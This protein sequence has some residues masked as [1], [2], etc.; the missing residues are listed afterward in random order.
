GGAYSVTVAGA[1]RVEQIGKYAPNLEYRTAPI[2]PPKGGIAKAGDSG[3]NFMIMPKTAKNREGAWKFVKFWSGLDDPA[4]AAEFYT[5][6]GWLPLSP[7]I[8]ESP[9]YQEYLRKYPQ[10]KTFLDMLPSEHLHTVPPVPYQVFLMDQIGRIQD[11]ALRGTVTPKEA[12][13]ELKREVEN[14]V[15]RRKEQ[16]L[17]H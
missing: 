12:L 16:G 8:A 2:P 6:G 15:Q 5:W 14:E 1:Y 4:R 3:G 13:Q 7:A 10:F 11:K 9:I 17:A